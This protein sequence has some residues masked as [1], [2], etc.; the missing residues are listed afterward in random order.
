MAPEISGAILP[1]RV[2]VG[3]RP[4]VPTSRERAIFSP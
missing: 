4:F 3:T 1:D 2:P